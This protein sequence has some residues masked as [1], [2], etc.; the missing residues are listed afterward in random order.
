MPSPLTPAALGPLLLVAAS[1]A[2]RV[3]RCD[4]VAS[5]LVREFVDEEARMAAGAAGYAW[6]E[7]CPFHPSQ[8]VLGGGPGGTTCLADY[9]ELFGVCGD[10]ASEAGGEAGCDQAGAAV[11]RKRC[12]AA[13]ARCFPL[14]APA[15]RRLHVQF[16]REWCQVLHC[17]A[18]EHWHR[19]RSEGHVS[20]VAVLAGLLC[21]VA[22]VFYLVLRTVENSGPP[23]RVVLKEEASGPLLPSLLGVRK[24]V[25]NPDQSE[26]VYC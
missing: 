23:C 26:K 22:C 2:G 17:G 3:E 12:D 21:A 16:S 1:A 5:R 20:L 11:A 8:D 6:P 4:P 7:G 10:R 19:S 15:A 14:D 9:C 18:R 25:R 24:R 13:V